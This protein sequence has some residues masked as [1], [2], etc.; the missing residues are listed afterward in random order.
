ML[1]FEQIFRFKLFGKEYAFMEMMEMI[2]EG[3]IVPERHC[4]EESIMKK[5]GL[6]KPPESEK[7]ERKTIQ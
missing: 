3:G 1:K 2:E 4:L 5:G 7:E 6:N